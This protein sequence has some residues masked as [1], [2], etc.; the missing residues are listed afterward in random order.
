MCVYMCH[1][2]TPKLWKLVNPLRDLHYVRSRGARGAIYE[3]N[4]GD[5]L[6]MRCGSLCKYTLPRQAIA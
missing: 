2:K 3:P 5:A 1:Y 6:S 4:D